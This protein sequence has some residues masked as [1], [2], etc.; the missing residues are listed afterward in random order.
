MPSAIRVTVTTGPDGKPELVGYDPIEDMVL[1]DLADHRSEVPHTWGLFLE[2]RSESDDLLHQ[3]A[4]DPVEFASIEFPTGDPARPLGRVVAPAGLQRSYL[5]PLDAAAA[6]IAMVRRWHDTSEAGT[7]EFTERA[8]REEELFSIE[9][10]RN[11]G[12]EQ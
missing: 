4:I 7:L 11:A 10:G 9:L 12:L 2:S 5:L 1:P 3:R 6:R 8:P